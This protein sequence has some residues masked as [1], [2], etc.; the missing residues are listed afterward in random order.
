MDE[1]ELTIEKSMAKGFAKMGS[2]DEEAKEEQNEAQ[3]VKQTIKFEEPVFR[4]QRDV[5][6]KRSQIIMPSRDDN[7]DHQPKK[8]VEVIS[9]PTSKMGDEFDVEW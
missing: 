7:K 8:V 9:E 5:I 2:I 3:E 1:Q 6:E 4:G